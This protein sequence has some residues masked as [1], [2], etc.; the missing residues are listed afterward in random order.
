M[1]DNGIT[2]ENLLFTLPSAIKEDTSTG[3]LAQAQA[4]LLADRIPETDI[5][6]IFPALDRQTE[7]VLDILAY[8]L[9]V[10]WYDYDYPVG[11][12]RALIRGS[13]LTHKRLGTLYAVL[14]TLRSLYPDSNVEEW[15][16]YGGEN[17]YF[18]VNV[19]IGQGA[20]LDALQVYS[21][22][23]IRR[24]IEAVKRL[25]AHLES[26]NFRHESQGVIRI[27]AY[28]AARTRLEIWPELV[29]KLELAGQAGV[30]AIAA[31]RQT[32]EVYPELTAKMEIT[33]NAGTGGA[34]AARQ[35]V[36]VYPELA[37]RI[38][39]TGQAG[40]GSI[41]A[42]RQTVEI[43]PE[44]KTRLDLT[45]QTGASSITAARQT[46]EIYPEF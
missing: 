29:S 3:A 10:D 44:L 5:P 45:A 8:D 1:S 18:R 14:S 28:T 22:E 41:T 6:R 25:A 46:V 35:T 37:S 42:A 31:A 19:N 38:E 36:E 32:V 39:V 17:G 4:Q 12:K 7:A 40:A 20:D 30:G 24:R 2:R 43:Y 16:E 9:K 21:A 26:I 33:G 34:T 15:F 27:G 13:V 23:E 11:T